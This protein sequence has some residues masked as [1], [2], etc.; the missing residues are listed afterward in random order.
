MEGCVN[1]IQN[2]PMAN[3]KT[4]FTFTQTKKENNLLEDICKIETVKNMVT[5]Q[6]WVNDFKH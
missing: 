2:L 4:S 6:T 3:M 1:S 5:K